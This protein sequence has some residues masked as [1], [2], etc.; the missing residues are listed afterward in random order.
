MVT[1]MTVSEQ[2]IAATQ[3]HNTLCL[4]MKGMKVFGEKYLEGSDSVAVVL[5]RSGDC[6]SG[7]KRAAKAM[8]SDEVP[9]R[10]LDLD[11]AGRLGRQ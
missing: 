4:C 11:G 6:G 7:R 5:S 2:W 1:T 10:A 3:K 9:G 8:A